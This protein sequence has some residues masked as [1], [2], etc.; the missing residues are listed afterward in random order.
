MSISVQQLTT[1]QPTQTAAHFRVDNQTVGD[2][3]DFNILDDA[4]AG[5]YVLF[6]YGVLVSA[7]SGG[8]GLVFNANW[9]DDTGHVHVSGAPVFGDTTPFSVGSLA[10]SSINDG[11]ATTYPTTIRCSGGLI[12]ATIVGDAGTS[13]AVVSW[14]GALVRVA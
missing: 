11:E 14:T 8:A 3:I 10:T 5:I 1:S 4:P 13:D 7:D 2:G 9:N 6:D 12:N